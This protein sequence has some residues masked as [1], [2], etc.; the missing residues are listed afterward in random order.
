MDTAAILFGFG[1]LI[2]AAAALAPAVI[3]LT[4]SVRKA[5]QKVRSR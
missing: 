1:A 4:G 5:R 2:M 3:S